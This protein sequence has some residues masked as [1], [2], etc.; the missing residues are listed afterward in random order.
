MKYIVLIFTLIL[1]TAAYS[2]SELNCLDKISQFTQVAPGEDKKM[3]GEN[4]DG[5]CDLELDY[6]KFISGITNE[7]TRD[8]YFYVN[9]ESDFSPGELLKDVRARISYND[10]LTRQT[11]RKCTII[12]DNVLKIE[13]VRKSKGGWRKKVKY[14]I[15]LDK[16]F[17]G[18]LK[19]RA[20][21]KGYSSI[22]TSGYKNS[23]NCDIHL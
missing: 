18:L 2:N 23:A 10:S 12:N 3:V 8:F 15:T 5:L 7:E 19:V 11:I 1:S 22:W 16:S 20:K 6:S 17:D 14:T 13:V 21:E 9:F 4:E